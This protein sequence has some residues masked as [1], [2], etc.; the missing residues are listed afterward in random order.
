MFVV[1]AD[2]VGVFH[3]GF[4]SCVCGIL[5]IFLVG[6]L[7]CGLFLSCVMVVVCVGVVV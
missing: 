7:Y 4:W 6:C 5:V 1:L 2:F 3:V